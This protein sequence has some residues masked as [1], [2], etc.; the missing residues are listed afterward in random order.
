MNEF[1]TACSRVL[2][3]RDS[4]KRGREFEKLVAGLFDSDEFT[5]HHNPKAAHPRQTDLIAETDKVTLLIEAKCKKRRVGVPDIANLHDR[6]RRVPTDVVGAMFST[7]DYAASAV[8]E[9]EANRTREILLFSPEEINQL[10]SEHLN[11]HELIQMKRGHLRTQ[12]KVWFYKQETNARKSPKLRDCHDLL[13]IDSAS[14]DS[15]NCDSLDSKILFARSIPDTSW[16]G[17][18]GPTVALTLRLML[19]DYRDLEG[20]L[21]KVDQIF[22]LSN[23]GSY[24][25]QQTSTSWFGFGAAR[26]IREVAGWERRYAHATL[27]EVH[28]AEGI[29]YFDRFRE[30]WIIVTARHDIRGGPERRFLS[31]ECIIQL[32]GIPVDMTPYARMCRET[33]N[34]D[35]RFVHVGTPDLYSVRLTTEYRLKVR[36]AIIS[37]KRLDDPVVTGLVVENPFFKASELPR[38]LLSRNIWCPLASINQAEFLICYLG[39]WHDYGDVVDYYFLREVEGRWAGDTI[40]LRPICTWH[41]MLKPIVTEEQRRDRFEKLIERELAESAE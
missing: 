12:G 32:S 5:V 35:A 30:G 7:S 8:R 23:E 29:A 26:F 15:V 34:A 37:N 27:K 20:F 16:A 4:R 11:L 24:S 17:V 38:E 28:H 22:G 39:N 3:L 40:V 31:G 33:N 14:V 10:S 25:I 18:G 19:R 21:A 9:A 2:K 13:K 6:L 1:G 41:K 36:G